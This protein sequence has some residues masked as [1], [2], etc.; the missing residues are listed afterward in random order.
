[1]HSINGDITLQGLYAAD[2][3]LK[4]K[5]WYYLKY[6]I[7]KPIDHLKIGSIYSHTFGFVKDI[8]SVYQN[9]VSFKA[10]SKFFEENNIISV[11]D[12][13]HKPILHIKEI[14]EFLKQEVIQL[15]KLESELLGSLPSINEV[16]AGVDRFGK[17]G[18]FIQL[19]K[20]SGGDVTKIK[21][22]K[23]LPYRTCISK[24]NLEY[25]KA[26]YEKD[27]NRMLNKH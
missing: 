8:Q 22:V 3:K 10:L 9:G 24:L 11:F 20:L 4:D 14:Q 18:S 23:F 19:D 13:E 12:F 5:I 7:F 26:E 27:L 17:Y 6:G 25:D 15:N 21:K 1:M 16:S 2:N